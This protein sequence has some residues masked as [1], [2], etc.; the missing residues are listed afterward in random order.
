M[1]SSTSEDE[2]LDHSIAVL[3]FKRSGHRSGL[4]AILLAAS[5]PEQSSGRIADLGA[6]AGVVGMA[7]AH[8]CPNVSVDLYEI[9]QALADLSSQ[10]LQL[11]QNQHLLGRVESLCADVRAAAS[12]LTAAQHQ[13]GGYSFVVA[14]P[15]FN[16]SSHRRSPDDRKSLAHSSPAAEPEKWLKTAATLLQNRGGVMMIVRPEN[17][18]DYLTALTPWFGGVCIK[19]IHTADHKP[20]N[21]V[22][23]AARK[24]SRSKTQLLPPL[25]VHKADGTFTDEAEEIL[26]GRAGITLLA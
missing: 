26:R 6:G 2:F 17:L 10:S 14:N 25:I 9:D 5:V 1:T 18:V 22:L 3:Q 16:D 4:D 15:P 13:Q 12:L 21:R 23:I 7:I 24:A 11:D 19:P 8:R 20:A